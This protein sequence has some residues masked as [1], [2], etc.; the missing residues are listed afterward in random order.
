MLNIP[1]TIFCDIDGVLVEH[2]ESFIPSIPPPKMTVLPGTKEKIKEWTEKN[3]III[4]TTG[5]KES[6]RGQTTYQLQEAGI[7]YDQ[8]I[9]GIGRGVR[10]LINDKKDDGTITALAFSPERNIGI[11]N[12]EI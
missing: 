2:N 9:M 11:K 10:V 12:I 4:L 6:L 3:Y 8:L 5:R 7:V 1:K